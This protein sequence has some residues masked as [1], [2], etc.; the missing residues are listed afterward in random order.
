MQGQQALLGLADLSIR[1][2]VLGA[3]AFLALKIGRVRSAGVQHA[4]WT[5]CVIAMLLLPVLVM[6]A[7]AIQIPILRAERPGIVT[8][9]VIVPGS[10]GVAR[11]TVSTISSTPR[12]SWAAAAW[13]VYLAIAAVLLVRL[14]V[15]WVRVVLL[16]R[17]ATPIRDERARG[18]R[19]SA[20]IAVPITAGVFRPGIVLPVS[21]REWDEATLS[22]VL[23]HESVHARRRDPL[24]AFVAAINRCAFWFHPLACWAEAKLRLLAEEA[25]DDECLTSFQDRERYVRILLDMAAA[26]RGRRSILSPAIA[27]ARPSQ[28]KRRVDRILAIGYGTSRGF[29]RA[30]LLVVLAAAAPLLFSIAAVRLVHA[31]APQATTDRRLRRQQEKLRRELETP[32]RKWLNEDV[33]YII[34]E[35]ERATFAALQTDEERERFI[36]QF[37]LWRDP[38]PSTRENEF[39]EEHYRRIAYSNERFAGGKPGWQTARGRTYIILGPPDEIESHAG[40]A[41]GWEAWRYRWIEQIG[42]QV[43]L[44]FG[45]LSDSAVGPTGFRAS[46]EP[47]Q[48]SNDPARIRELANL[49]GIGVSSVTSGPSTAGTEIA[50]SIDPGQFQWQATGTQEQFQVNVYGRVVDSNGNVVSVFEDVVTRTRNPGSSLSSPVWY[51]HRIKVLPAGDY[52]VHIVLKDASGHG[53]QNREMTVTVPSR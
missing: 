46:G 47:V 21:W 39:K 20:A 24:L 35:G 6:L 44:E 34:T 50:F 13:Y 37:W 36:E 28:V 23:L 3:V 32:Y 51:W 45:D 52:R 1:A 10:F 48:R 30:G 19:E 18:L 41:N 4:A 40:G 12:I 33:V 2:A 7:P 14:L 25:T 38:T 16:V 11:S 8:S 43:E 31:A 15:R 22:A 53:E 5:F 26:A 42:A 27:M 17:R 49:L 29:T 9:F